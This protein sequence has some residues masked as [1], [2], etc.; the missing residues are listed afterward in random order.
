LQ[1]I[2][3]KVKKME[4]EC[5][6]LLREDNNLEIKNSAQL[7]SEEKFT[8]IKN[9]PIKFITGYISN[10]A[11]EMKR[12]KE[13]LKN[14]IDLHYQLMFDNLYS[15]QKECELELH[16]RDLNY[17]DTF[18][19]D[20][21]H[22]LADLERTLLIYKICEFKINSPNLNLDEHGKLNITQEFQEQEDELKTWSENKNKDW[23]SFKIT[24]Y[25][26]IVDDINVSDKD[27]LKSMREFLENERLS[28]K[29]INILIQNSYAANWPNAFKTK[30]TQEKNKNNI[31][32][33][34][35]CIYVFISVVDWSDR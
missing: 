14:D 7:T 24:D 13:K 3:L 28:E 1:E 26:E 25:S 20:V 12:Q 15:F 32:Q 9:E 5:V 18:N 2:N 22:K 16:K 17:Y 23:H 34:T 27:W 29:T 4:N 35:C 19:T 21:A 31:K 8:Q 30:E 11:I 10:I 33:L 6:N